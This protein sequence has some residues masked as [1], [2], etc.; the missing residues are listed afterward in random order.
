MTRTIAISTAACLLGFVGAVHAS[1]EYSWRATVTSDRAM[2][3]AGTLFP[4]RCGDSGSLCGI[5]YDDRRGCPFEFVVVFPRV[6]AGSTD[7]PI[8]IVTLD[9]HGAVLEV[10][11]SKTKSCRSAKS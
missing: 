5:T 9:K 2:K 8:A 7:P 1:E 4:E 10:S 6:E 11:S 3:I